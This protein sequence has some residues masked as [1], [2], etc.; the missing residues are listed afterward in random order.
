MNSLF[1]QVAQTLLAH[2]LRS[3]LAIIAIVWGML[4]V[5][6]LVALGEGFYRV[7]TQ[8]FA[9]LMSDTQMGFPSQTTKPWQGLPAKRPIRISEEQMH[10]LARQSAIEQLSVMY[11]K[12]D[13]NVTN[14]QGRSLP[15]YVAGVDEHYFALQSLTLRSASRAITPNDV[16]NHARVAIIGWQ[17][18][19]VGQLALGDS[20]KVNGVPFFI[21]GITEQKEGGVSL[22]NESNQLMIP[23][24]TFTDLWQSKPYSLLVK[25]KVD[26]PG[27]ALRHTIQTFFAKQ[28]HYDPTDSE[29]V[30][31]PD[32]S[33]GAQFINALFRGIQLFLGA[34]G[35]ITLAVGALGVANIMFLSVTERT[36][37]IGVRLAV[38]ATPNTILWQ[39]ILEGTLLVALGCTFGIGLS[40]LTIATLNQLG[41]PDWLGT[42]I[43]TSASIVGS[44]LIT[45]CLALCAAYFPARRAAHL[46]PVLALSARG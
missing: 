37:E 21:I 8:S 28:Q 6:V 16:L 40:Y 27:L 3:T 41:L 32:F 39:F 12:W 29:A 34:S 46:T 26:I 2:R 15:G 45:A 33:S 38:G 18:A 13:A 9:L 23:S 36:R 22:N 42:P 35:M 24:T 14:A 17:L 19:Q 11:G 20:V 10:A 5:L 31:L 44:L 30:Y 1:L 7:N 4:S 25:P 43:I